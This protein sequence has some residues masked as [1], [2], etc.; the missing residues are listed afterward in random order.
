[1]SGTYTARNDEGDL[2]EV[3][4]E[5][6]CHCINCGW[7]GDREDSDPGPRFGTRSCPEC[8]GINLFP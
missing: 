2:V 6:D 5:T 8:G 1:M 3:E 4:Y 7:E